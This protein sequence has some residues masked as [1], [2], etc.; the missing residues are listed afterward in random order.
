MKNHLLFSVYVFRQILPPTIEVFECLVA[1]ETGMQT[2]VI[3]LQ[4]APA[5][6]LA[7]CATTAR[8]VENENSPSKGTLKMKNPNYEKHQK[9]FT[10]HILIQQEDKTYQQKLKV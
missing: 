2:A 6:I 5:I 8:T 1:E 4:T 7:S 3:I 10:E 9:L